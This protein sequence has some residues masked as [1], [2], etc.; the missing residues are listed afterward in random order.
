[1]K[2]FQKYHKSSKYV[3][4]EWEDIQQNNLVM[5]GND[6]LDPAHYVDTESF[7]I[8]QIIKNS[9]G[10]DITYAL[11][12]TDQGKKILP[13]L[14][15]RFK[16]GVATREFGGC[17]A[18]EIIMNAMFA[19]IMVIIVIKYSMALLFQ[20]FIARRLI[21]PGGRSNWFLAWRSVR[22]GN[23]DPI[24]H[25]SHASVYEYSS[26]GSNESVSNRQLNN[27]RSDIVN[28]AL[29]TVM[30]VTCYSEGEEG[31]RTTMDSLSNTT[32]SK[33][34]KVNYVHTKAKREKETKINFLDIFCNCRWID[35]RSWG[36]EINT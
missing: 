29:Y 34:H 2:E 21:T 26:H 35:H 3:S 30:L 9:Q 10:N 33:D 1:M 15:A 14:V 17:I 22:G 16:V 32:Y 25:P 5:V 4:F 18:N 6:V 12:Y 13:C 19:V 27:T 28:I 7:V 20:W 8:N 23:D 36:R 31:L 11:L 24:N